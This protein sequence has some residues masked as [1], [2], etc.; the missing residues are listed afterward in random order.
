MS[1][2]SYGFSPSYYSQRH[3]NLD[4]LK[5]NTNDLSFLEKFNQTFSK[6]ESPKKREVS[7]L[8]SPKKVNKS[9]NSQNNDMLVDVTNL[10][11][12]HSEGI[13]RDI[14]SIKK[15]KLSDSV[16]FSET[17][18][19]TESKISDMKNEI[20][21]NRYQQ[22]IISYEGDFDD[23]VTGKGTCSCPPNINCSGD[24][25]YGKLHGQG[26]AK[27]ANGDIYEGGFV[28]GERHGQG[29]LKNT[30]GDIYYG[31]FVDNNLHGQGIEDLVK[32]CIYVGG[33]VNGYR[34]GQGILKL[35]DG[36]SYMGE[37]AYGKLHGQGIVKLP[38]GRSYKAVYDNDKWQDV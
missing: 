16:S 15:S 5:E 13:I 36:R 31:G 9:G 22:N 1:I 17:E 12:G 32:G 8:K 26:I 33:F 19:E 21:S 3:Q 11:R 18:I 2:N 29:T 23:T 28:N 37:F 4:A 25:V 10:K 38:D 20:Y 27:Y 14:E 30:S 7:H 6:R 35:S 34:H 24:F